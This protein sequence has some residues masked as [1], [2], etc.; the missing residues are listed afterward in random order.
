MCIRDSPVFGKK[1]GKR[2]S[3]IVDAF[4]VLNKHETLEADQDYA[5][6]GMPNIDEWEDP[7]NLDSFGNPKFNPS[8]TPSTYYKTPI[9]YQA[10]RSLQIGIKLAF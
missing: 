3:I 7:S 6:E 10:P 2:L 5:Y 1:S 9:L 4:N 8:L